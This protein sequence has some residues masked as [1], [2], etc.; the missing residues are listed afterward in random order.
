[1]KISQEMLA[2]AERQ[3][4]RYVKEGK[5]NFNQ[6]IQSES[7]RMKQQ[8]LEKLMSD[9]TKQS[10]K[11]ATFRSFRDL[12]KFKRMIKQFLQEAVYNG[13]ELDE[14]RSFHM[15]SFSNK[16]TTVKNVDEKLVQLTEDLMD[17]EKKTVDIL[18]TIGEIEGLLINLY[19]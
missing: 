4:V 5:H 11:I 15:D 13:L 19:T 10:E 6:M 16:L 9:I 1:M 12:A 17:Q 8:E 18:G 7:A 14:V 3:P 2:K